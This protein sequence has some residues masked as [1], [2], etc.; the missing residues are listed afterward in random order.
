MNPIFFPT[1]TE[2]RAWLA[3]HHASVDEAWVGLYKKGTGRPSITW[4]ELVDELLCFGWIDGLRRS[5]GPE[6]YALR[7]TPRRTGS[8]WSSI[9]LRRA[10]ELMALGRM[11]APGRAAFEAAY[12]RE[13]AAR[14]AEREAAVLTGAQ[15]ARFRANGRAWA[16]FQALP[17]GYRKQAVAWVN[18]AKR[19]ET[20]DRRLATLI[21][22]SQEG[23]KIAPL[24]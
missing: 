17:P 9:N 23:L 15:E 7:I 21:R 10:R 22:D 19:E 5:L 16:F 12:L 2:L 18:S 14:A 13:S 24:R 6:S 11:E 1:S 20:R 3:E 8:Q 4:P